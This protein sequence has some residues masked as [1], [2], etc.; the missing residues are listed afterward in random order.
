MISVC[1]ATFNGEKYIKEQLDS[2][3][4]QLCRD[5]EIIISDDSSTDKTIDIIKSY[6][7]DRI[8]ILEKQNFKSPIY[9]FEN[10]L[11]FASGEYIFLSDQDD[12]WAENKV[13]KMCEILVEYDLVVCDCYWFGS[14]KIVNISN[15]EFRNA[16]KGVVKN[17][18]KNGYLGNCMAF[19]AKLLKKVLPF[20]K[21]IPMHD[22]WIGI[23][24]NIHF[25]VFFLNEKLSFWRRHD[26]NTTKLNNNK[27]PYN[28]YKM[29][30]MRLNLIFNLILRSL[31]K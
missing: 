24:A 26:N 25:K 5:D 29:V 4:P 9:N 27:S 31:K 6:N 28:L 23:V 20:P 15:F 14:D 7:D 19:R 21:N 30:N 10:A 16:G 2:I 12:K 22:I 3:M 8:I 11:R 1:I 17:I 13:K 18:I